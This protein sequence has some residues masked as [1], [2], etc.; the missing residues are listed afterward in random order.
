MKIFV[1]CQKD[2]FTK[3]FNSMQKRY[4]M[5][6]TFINAISDKEPVVLLMETRHEGL[7]KENTDGWGLIDEL[8]AVLDAADDL[9]TNNI[10]A[11]ETNSHIAMELIPYVRGVFQKTHEDVEFVGPLLDIGILQNIV[12]IHNTVPDMK[13]KV[14]LRNCG[15]TN[16]DMQKA[17]VAI[18]KK[19]GVGIS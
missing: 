8:Q 11:M 4:N 10:L 13:I 17:A 2:A 5:G 14:D 7:C 1:N 6:Q 3:S 15:S 9:H 12:L 19:M 18:L 16:R